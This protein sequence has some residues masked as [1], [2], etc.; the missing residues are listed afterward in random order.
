MIIENNH[1][2]RDDTEYK[3]EGRGG[4][5]NICGWA[6]GVENYHGGKSHMVN[7]H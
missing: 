1:G 4:I 5:E 2:G 6:D 7:N 3:H